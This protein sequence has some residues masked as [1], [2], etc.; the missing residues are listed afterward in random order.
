M[1]SRIARK[2]ASLFNMSA[3]LAGAVP[4]VVAHRMARMA[5]AG[6]APSKRDRDEFQRMYDEKTVA[7]TRSWSAMGAAAMAFWSPALMT[8][9]PATAA[10]RM[11][12]AALGVMTQ[13]MAPVWRTAMANAKRL[14]RAQRG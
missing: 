4:M 12:N 6:A 11:Q 3:G 5:L 10:A 1:T 9:T 7:F 2:T 8:G 13:G 14:G